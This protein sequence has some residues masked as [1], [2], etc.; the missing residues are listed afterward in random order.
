[1]RG[2]FALQGAASIPP[3]PPGECSG[4]VR[5]RVRVRVRVMV[6]VMVMVRVRVRVS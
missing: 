3:T 5:I 6:M 4:R 2:R 1:M